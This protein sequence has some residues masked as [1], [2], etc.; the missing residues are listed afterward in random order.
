MDAQVGRGRRA[1]RGRP[2]S[3]RCSS[4]TREGKEIR[5]RPLL[6]SRTRRFAGRAHRSG[7]RDSAPHEAVSQA[8]AEYDGG[9]PHRNAGWPRADG[10]RAVPCGQT[11]RGNE[12]RRQEI[13]NHK[14][15]DNDSGLGEVQHERRKRS[16]REDGAP[17]GKCR[18]HLRLARR[19]QNGRGHFVPITYSWGKT[20]ARSGP[21]QPPDLVCSEDECRTFIA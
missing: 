17:R 3:Q 8:S 2:Q 16:T 7:G 11:G 12:R 13:R 14:R 6:P 1:S 21:R 20:E 9:F 15:S 4:R 5:S 10:D 19:N 18:G